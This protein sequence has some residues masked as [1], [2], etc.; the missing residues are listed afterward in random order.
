[1]STENYI[2]VHHQ[3][4]ESVGIWD[5]WVFMPNHVHFLFRTGK[6]PLATVGN[7]KRAWQDV[8]YVLGYFGNTRHIARTRY[9][10]YLE[11]GL[12][13][14][15]RDELTGGGLIRSLGGWS[16]AKK[17]GSKGPEHFRSDEKI[18][19]E[20]NFVSDVLSQANEAFDRKYVLKHLG[21]GM[22]SI[23]GRLCGF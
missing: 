2:L 4:A 17:Y 22:D 19:G 11:A 8:A 18:L 16:E 6:D 15:R 20:S 12:G 7:Q 1:M 23:A 10:S 13:Q 9:F 21:Y 3:D 5:A 14:G